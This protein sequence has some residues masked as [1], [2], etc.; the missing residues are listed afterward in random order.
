MKTAIDVSIII[1]NYRVNDRL[2]SCLRSIYE[3]KPRDNFEIVVVDNS[4][5]KTIGKDLKKNFPKIKYVEPEINLGFGAGNN[6]GAKS[7]KGK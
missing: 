7:A 6:L 2:L 5:K 1:V 4:E 3:S